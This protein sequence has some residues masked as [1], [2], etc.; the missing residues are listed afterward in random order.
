MKISSHV[1]VSASHVWQLCSAKADIENKNMFDVIRHFNTIFGKA[2]GYHNH[3]I[4]V[5]A[6]SILENIKIGFF[7]I[8]C[9]ALVIWKI[10]MVRVTMS[11]TV[12]CPIRHRNTG[13]ISLRAP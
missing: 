8:T 9:V 11:W 10:S 13:E 1:Y 3:I 5:M 4:L 7:S 6:F 2:L 12:S